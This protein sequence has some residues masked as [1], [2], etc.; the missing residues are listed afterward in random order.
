MSREDPQMKLRLP[1]DL[2]QQIEEVAKANNRSMNA[3]IVARLQASLQPEV[4]GPKTNEVFD[5][6]VERIEHL[7]ELLEDE[8]DEMG[9]RRRRT[10]DK[11][12]DSE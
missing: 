1:L 7:T 6:L 9:L 12:P 10:H 4:L 2:K 11:T 8:R 3:E 5:A